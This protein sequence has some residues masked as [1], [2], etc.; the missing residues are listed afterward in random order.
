VKR[1]GILLI[2]ALLGAGIGG[3]GRERALSVTEIDPGV[4]GLALGGA[5]VSAAAGAEILYYN[6]SGLAA[7]GSSSFQSFY[8]SQFAAADYFALGVVFPSFGLGLL[9]LSSGDIA[10]YD[11]GGNPTETLRYRSTAILLG[12]GASPD[13]L[14]FLPQLPVD[15]ALGT[16]V[17]LLSSSLGATGGFG[18]AL[19]LAA[20]LGFGSMQIGPVPLDDITVGIHATNLLGTISYDGNAETLLMD[21]RL[22][23]STLIVRQVLLLL[24]FEFSGRIHVGVEYSPIPTVALRVGFVQQAPG[25]SLTLG[26]GLDLEGFGLDYAFMGSTGLSGSHRVALSVDFASI[27]LGALTGMLRRIL[28]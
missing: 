16:R 3:W 15:Y 18:F 23:A 4:R 26:A 28:P 22:G 11:A 20:T 1:L 5:S 13:T 17:K 24:D 25:I 27:D 21:L 8:A 14:R 6:P 9:N 2:V 10:G 7:L 12:Y 19:D